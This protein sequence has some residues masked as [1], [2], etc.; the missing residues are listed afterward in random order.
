[1]KKLVSTLTAILG[2][3]TLAAQDVVVKGPDEKLQLAVFVQNETK[4][5][6]SVSYNGKTMLEKSPLGMNTNIGDFTKNLKLTGHSVDKI[7]TVY[8][9]TRIKVSNVH[10]RAN[11]LTC[12]LENEQ[13]QKL[14]VIFRVSDNDVAFRYTLPHQGGK[15]S[16][17]VKEEQTGFRFPEQTTTFLCPQ[18]DAMIGWKR[19]KPSYE[20]E[21]KADA[22]MSDRSQYGH[23]YTFPCLFRIGNDGWVLVSETG[24]DSRYCGSRL[25]V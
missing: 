22:P 10:Y 4:P 21:Y 20:E 15:A 8:Q 12:H 13:G 1:M 3:S 9:Q 23:G 16:V 25:S 19:T 2:I 7:D 24:V 6:Y 11:E 17:T 5:C 18:S 14:G